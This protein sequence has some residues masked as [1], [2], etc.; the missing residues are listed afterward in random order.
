MAT[1][2]NVTSS[3]DVFDPHFLIISLGNPLPYADCLH[4]AGHIALRSLQQQLHRDA[5]HS[6][7]AFTSERIG[8]KSTQ[9][10]R[11]SKYTLLQSPT[12]MNVSGP[13]VAK[14]WREILAETGTQGPLGLVVVHD[15][16]EEDMA[17]VKIRKWERSHRGHNGLKSINAIM[18][19][20]DFGDSKWAKVSVGIGRPEG[21]DH[22]TVSDYVLRPLSKYQHGVL[23][24]KS[25]SSVLA[26]LEE[27][28]AAWRIQRET[29]ATDEPG[30]LAKAKPP[31]IRAAKKAKDAVP[32]EAVE[33]S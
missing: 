13:W 5:S 16:L 29:G 6:Q 19:P 25:A 11:G 10:S 18:R 20:A 31:K 23:A 28:E 12:L 27:I 21:R 30:E 15:D 1:E 17:V 22:G 2:P 33:D 4:S 14:A 26:A 8:K 24:E 3:E 9:T 32:Q 7:P